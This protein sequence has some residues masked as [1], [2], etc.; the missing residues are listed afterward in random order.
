M[1]APRSACGY[2]DARSNYT[3]SLEVMDT[4]VVMAFLFISVLV[5]RA[6]Y[7]YGRSAYESG[8]YGRPFVPICLRNSFLPIRGCEN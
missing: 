3:V 5:A 8:E 1:S 7:L 4:I 2:K 6:N